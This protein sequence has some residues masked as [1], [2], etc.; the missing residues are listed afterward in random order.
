MRLVPEAWGGSLSNRGALHMRRRW[1]IMPLKLR[2][3][4]HHPAS[5]KQVGL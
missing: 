1:S 3:R 4:R 2:R 5:A